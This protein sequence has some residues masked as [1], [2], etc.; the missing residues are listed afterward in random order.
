MSRKYRDAL[1]RAQTNRQEAISR[2]DRIE[3]MF[4]HLMDDYGRA[5]NR[6]NRD[7][8]VNIYDREIAQLEPLAQKEM[9]EEM[10]QNIMKG[11]SDSSKGAGKQ[12][13]DNL[14]SEIGKALKELGFK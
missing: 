12:I 11:V 4:G 8:F 1:K 9:E 13:A 7:T 10:I 5:W 14:S 6:H 3:S 2:V